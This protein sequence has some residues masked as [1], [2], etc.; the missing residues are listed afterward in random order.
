MDASPIS[1]SS[2]PWPLVKKIA[3]RFFFLYFLFYI[4]PFPFSLF[5][6]TDSISQGF[7]DI[8]DELVD[9]FASLLGFEGPIDS[10]MTG[11]GDKTYDFL[12]NFLQVILAGFGIVFWSFSDRK[13]VSYSTLLMILFILLRYYL[14]WNMLGYGF[15]K[16]FKLQFP[17]PSLFRLVQPYGESSPM[18]L[19]WTYMGSSATYTWFAGAMEVLG[20]SMLL[21]R[22]TTTLGALVSLA[23]IANIFMMNMSYDIPVKLFSLNLLLMAL[24]IA[25]PDMR[26]L[27]NILLANRA[28][29][30][31]DQSL[32]LNKRWKKIT[33]WILKAIFI[34]YACIWDGIETRQRLEKYGENSPKPPH[35]GIYDVEQFILN[36]DTIA[37]L[38]TDTTRWKRIII[39]YPGMVGFY[40]MQDEKTYYRFELDSVANSI[41]VSSFADSTIVFAGKL[42]HTDSVH[43]EW[44]GMQQEDTLKVLLNRFDE[45]Q[46][47][48]LNRGFHW[49]NEVPFNR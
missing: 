5:D 17:S 22:R 41:S 10:S 21:F 20:G 42:E 33:R 27:I 37:P 11:S 12:I 29:T 48:L 44:T 15:I 45:Q 13:R 26:R 43:Y 35:Y 2:S 24:F 16:V 36:S 8:W 30:P 34:G 39:A 6:F 3:F 19:A 49:V 23:V 18:G 40:N 32:K 25:L 31:R 14:A 46:F 1:P 28:T 47:R 7:S 4:L 38:L 9:V